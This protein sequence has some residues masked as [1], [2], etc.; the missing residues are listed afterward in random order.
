MVSNVYVLQAP[1]VS[2]RARRAI[3]RLH[4]YK[5]I[6]GLSDSS[7]N[8]KVPEN[9]GFLATGWVFW[10]EKGRPLGIFH[11]RTIGAMRES[12]TIAQMGHLAHFAQAALGLTFLMLE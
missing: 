7:I 9:F 12:L 10:L 3:C 2:E 5:P 8:L 6:P 1:S 11:F 4:R